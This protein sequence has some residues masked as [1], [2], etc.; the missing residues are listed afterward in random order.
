MTSKLIFVMALLSVSCEMA[1]LTTASNPFLKAM[2]LSI[3]A[4]SAPEDTDVSVAQHHHHCRK[5]VQKF[6][7]GVHGFIGVM[8]C[9]S[10]HEKQL[11]KA[12]AAE[13]KKCPMFHCAHDMMTL[14][15]HEHS[16]AGFVMCLVKH[17]SQ[18]C[19]E[20]RDDIQ[21][22]RHRHHPPGLAERL[23]D[24]ADHE[25]I[26]NDDEE[27]NQ[28]NDKDAQIQSSDDEDGDEKKKNWFE[29]I[30]QGHIRRDFIGIAKKDRRDWDENRSDFHERGRHHHYHR[31]GAMVLIGLGLVLLI[32]T[33][34]VVVKAIRRRR[35]RQS[36][37]QDNV[38][39]FY[40]AIHED[41]PAPAPAASAVP[42]P[43]SDLVPEYRRLF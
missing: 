24:E 39:F 29:Q 40:E 22:A 1:T 26:E 15:P 17:H 23:Q 14:C 30:R 41:A 35:R 32:S 5:D 33:V 31:V 34:F 13:V 25:F 38:P 4:I 37:P 10:D 43:Q 2:R 12:C 8:A 16:H 36:H 42:P 6:C 28:P 21:R 11:S 3:V 18:L 9:L 19:K 20:C 27:K 7:E